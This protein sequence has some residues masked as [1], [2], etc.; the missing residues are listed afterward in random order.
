MSQEDS[1]LD[2]P[3]PNMLLRWFGKLVGIIGTLIVSLVT[4]LGIFVCVDFVVHSL[5]DV[6]IKLLD[7]LTKPPS[8]EM[9]LRYVLTGEDEGENM[10]RQSSLGTALP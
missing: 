1:G 2:N 10:E 4:F 3:F 6:L 7:P 8:Y 5:S 9:V